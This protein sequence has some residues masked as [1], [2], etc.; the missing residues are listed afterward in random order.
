MDVWIVAAA[1][2]AGYVAQHW[3]NIVRGRRSFSDSSCESP[4]FRPESSSSTQQVRDK[5]SCPC[6]V[7]QGKGLSREVFSERERLSVDSSM[8]EIASTGQFDC[9][10]RVS[11]GDCADCSTHSAS[12]LVPGLSRYEDVLVNR[13]GVGTRDDKDETDGDLSLSTSVRE[14]SVSYGFGRTKSSL[15]SRRTIGQSIKPLN[16]LESCLMA[17][18]YKEPAEREEYNFSSISSPC[19]P[20]VRPFVVTDGSRIISRVSGN[21]CSMPIGAV[22]NRPLTATNLEDIFGVPRLPSLGSMGFH[23]KAK[24]D[25]KM[26]GRLSHSS[27]AKGKHQ[28]LQGG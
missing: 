11:L 14:M 21:P 3:K 24:T 8:A 22:Q 20:I 19:T 28:S 9:P 2:G 27:G 25:I 18:L 5:S 1:A 13:E 6:D 12:D 26:E 16:S 10:N 17:Q 23:R 4:G 15:R 7:V